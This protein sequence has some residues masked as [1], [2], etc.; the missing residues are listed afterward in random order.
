MR[1]NYLLFLFFSLVQIIYNLN[2]YQMWNMKPFVKNTDVCLVLNLQ[3]TS[4]VLEINL[5]FLEIYC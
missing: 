5:I 4:Q 2:N 1:F 3:G